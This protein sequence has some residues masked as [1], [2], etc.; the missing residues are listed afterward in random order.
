MSVPYVVVRDGHCGPAR[1]LPIIMADEDTHAVWHNGATRTGPSQNPGATSAAGVPAP[2][3][4]S[5]S[6]TYVRKLAQD[7][8]PPGAGDADG[9][10]HAEAVHQGPQPG[11]GPAG[12]DGPELPGGDAV[13]QQLREVTLPGVLDGGLPG[14]G[15]VVGV[16][17]AVPDLQPERPVRVAVAVGDIERDA[18]VEPFACGA[19]PGEQGPAFGAE[20]RLAPFEGLQQQLVLGPEVVQEV[21]AAHPDLAAEPRHGEPVEP[22]LGDGAHDGG[23]HVLPGRGDVATAR[24]TGHGL[25]S[26]AAAA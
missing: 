6:S 17:R 9:D 5:V 8:L 16:L 23:E 4:V 10:V 2:G 15:V 11:R 20:P 19:G 14:A 24:G 12:A 26:W 21:P 13:G 22:A 1:L 25:R 18:G 7:L 3:G